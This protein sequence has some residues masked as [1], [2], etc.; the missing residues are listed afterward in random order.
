[1][2]CLAEVVPQNRFLSVRH[3]KQG[4]RAIIERDTH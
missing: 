4:D 3:A 2:D 1:M